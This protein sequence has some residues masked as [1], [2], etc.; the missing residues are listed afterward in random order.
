MHGAIVLAAAEVHGQ[1]ATAHVSAEQEVGEECGLAKQGQGG[2]E[3]VSEQGRDYV[4]GLRYIA[5]SCVGIRG[6]G[7]TEGSEERAEGKCKKSRDREGGGSGGNEERT[8]RD[9]GSAE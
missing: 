8:Y 4:E 1:S 5:H 6:A 3:G 9:D 2:V 7:E